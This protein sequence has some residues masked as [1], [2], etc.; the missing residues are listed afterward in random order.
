MSDKMSSCKMTGLGEHTAST[1]SRMY[2][3]ELARDFR[4]KNLLVI[5]LIRLGISI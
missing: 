2:I 5:T 3:E 1:A 4:F